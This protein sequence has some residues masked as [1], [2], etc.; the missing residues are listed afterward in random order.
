MIRL[1]GTRE[2]APYRWVHPD[3][4]RECTVCYIDTRLHWGEV[5]SRG[6][7][8]SAEVVHL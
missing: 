2:I 7:T 5:E 8:A 4:E 3:E 6:V 1:T